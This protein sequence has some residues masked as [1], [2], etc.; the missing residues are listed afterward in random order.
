MKLAI[1]DLGTN[2][3]RLAIYACLG[4]G[5]PEILYKK[6]FMLRPGAGVF[7]TGR[8]KKPVM[9][10]IENR[11]K[12]FSRRLEREQVDAVLAV[13]TSATREAENG[14]EFVRRIKRNTGLKL[15]IISGREEAKLIAQ[16]ILHYE[17]HLPNKFCLV[18]IGG[19][20]TEVVFGQR[21]RSRKLLS[22]PLGA[23]RL[24]QFLFSLGL[25][26]TL[27]HRLS[28]VLKLKQYI[29]EELRANIPQRYAGSNQIIVGSSG[30]I[31]ALARILSPRRYSFSRKQLRSLVERMLLMSRPQLKRLRGMDPRRTDIILVG[32]LLLLEI[33]DHLQVE[34]LQTTTFAL[35]DGL[36]LQGVKS[37]RSHK[38]FKGRNRPR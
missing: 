17:T 12:K 24:K 13:A 34:R 38:R 26:R 10:R 19:G 7:V 23:L 32:A 31:R 21:R 29:Q 37:L 22:L 16:G 20:S 5:Q 6:K 4:D 25:G 18:D 36:L 30:T 27:N 14:R 9:R 3:M 2:S 35:R 1:I 11:L 28:A 8:L 33:M 15:Q